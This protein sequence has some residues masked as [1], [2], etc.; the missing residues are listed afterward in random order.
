MRGRANRPQALLKGKNNLAP[1]IGGFAYRIEGLTVKGDIN[2]A[3][4]CGM[5]RQPHG[6]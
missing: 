6:G 1:D 2:T 5:G 3:R 4:S